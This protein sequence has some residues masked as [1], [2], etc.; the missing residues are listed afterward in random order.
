AGLSAEVRAAIDG[1]LARRRGAPGTLVE[2]LAM[3]QRLIEAHERAYWEPDAATLAALQAASEELEDRLE[4]IAPEPTTAAAA[5]PQ[6]Q[7]A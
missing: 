4:G 5:A 6:P 3:R 7:E 2:A 1:A